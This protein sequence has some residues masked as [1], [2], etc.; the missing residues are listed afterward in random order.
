M[1]EREFVNDYFARTLTIA[2]K[3]KSNGENKGG[4]AV[5]DK[6]I[7]IAYSILYFIVFFIL[8]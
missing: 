5:V 1:N 7:R 6:I 2:N 3:M 4:I 8:V